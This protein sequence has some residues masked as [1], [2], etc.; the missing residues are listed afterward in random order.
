MILLAL[1]S[2]SALLPSCARSALDIHVFGFDMERERLYYGELEKPME[3]VEF[4][5][6]KKDVQHSRSFIAIKLDDWNSVKAYCGK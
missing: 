1:V 5:W 6:L 4:E 3:T 2:F